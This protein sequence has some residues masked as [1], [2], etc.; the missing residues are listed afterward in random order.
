MV[1]QEL[2]A[3]L[4]RAQSMTPTLAL[5]E[6]DMLQDCEAAADLVGLPVSNS[7]F[8]MNTNGGGK[9][10]RVLDACNILGHGVL[11]A[12]GDLAKNL[13]NTSGSTPNVP[14]FPPRQNVPSVFQ[15]PATAPPHHPHQ[16][17]RLP[18][19]LI[20]HAHT[21]RRVSLALDGVSKAPSWV[22]VAKLNP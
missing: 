10:H 7:E 16:A 11:R 4:Q 14:S 5:P 9:L 12:D 22:R 17:H 20:P 18:P 1:K 6:P 3:L 19:L 2:L 13:L 21:C 15:K 8:I